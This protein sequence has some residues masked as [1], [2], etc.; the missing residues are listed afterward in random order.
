MELIIFLAAVFWAYKSFIKDDKKPSEIESELKSLIRFLEYVPDDIP[1]N[2]RTSRRLMQDR[3]ERAKERNNKFTYIDEISYEERITPHK[4]I[5]PGVKPLKNI[6][7]NDEYCEHRIELNPNI[8]YSAQ[9][10]VQTKK[11][12]AVFPVSKNQIING[13]IWSEILGKPKSLRR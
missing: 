5:A 3:I 1:Q 9:K 8:Q 7:N 2:K 13:V 4:R 11:D 6:Y 12:S 10:T